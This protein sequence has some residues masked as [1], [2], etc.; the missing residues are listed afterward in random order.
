MRSCI[1][2]CKR[3]LTITALAALG[4]GV[5]PVL[6]AESFLPPDMHAWA[7]AVTDAIYANQ[8]HQAEEEAQNI[9][10][11]YPAHP[12]GYFFM[13]VALDAW[14]VMHYSNKKEDEFYRFCE[15]AVDLGEELLD[16]DENN[17]WARFFI[18][19][20]EGY[21][22]TFE[23]RFRHWI[24][25]FRYGWKG[26]SAFKELESR[27]STILDINYGI[28]CYE[29][30]RSAL[31]RSLWW[32]PRIEDRRF[33][34]I[35]RLRKVLDSGVYTKVPASA[36]LSDILLNEGRDGEALEV[37][38]AALQR[39]P[40]S[41]FFMLRKARALLGLHKYDSSEAV[42]RQVLSQAETNQAEEH[43]VIAVCHF[44]ICKNYLAQ[45]RYA[46]CIAECDLMKNYQFNDDSKDALEKYFDEVEEF[47]NKAVV[48]RSDA[49]KT[50][51]GEKKQ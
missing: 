22:G 10:R 12:A 48:A 11:K 35:E 27:K 13:A 21:K 40:Y 1:Y 46:D 38:Q 7:L 24:T 25:A 30:W 9:I 14:M 15:Q 37:V 42:F 34:G 51:Q 32:M 8:Y 41:T 23:A 45:G 43:A 29:Y 28:G 5:F 16:E 39:Y 6:A 26:M 18:G 50:A 47:K 20:A 33:K 3:A 44:W 4:A 31:A 49:M 2:Y 17:D 36:S 19:G